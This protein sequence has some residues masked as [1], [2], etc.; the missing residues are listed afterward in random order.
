[1]FN[2]NTLN[3]TVCARSPDPFLILYVQEVVTLQ[4]N[5]YYVCLHYLLTIMILQVE[6]YS[7]TEQNNFRSHKFNWIKYSIQYFRSGHNFLDIRYV[8]QMPCVAVTGCGCRKNN[9]HFTDPTK[10]SITV[11][12]GKTTTCCCITAAQRHLANSEPRKL[13]YYESLQL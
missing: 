7:F 11:K 5:I 2:R 9:V 1:M 3:H 6:Y 8:W 13:L 4:K 12:L 10:S